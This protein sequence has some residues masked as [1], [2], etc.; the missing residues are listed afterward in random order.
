L[1][2]DD[3]DYDDDDDDDDDEEEVDDDAVMGGRHS[4]LRF[5]DS[6]VIFGSSA[7]ELIRTKLL[8]SEL[9]YASRDSK[10][11]SLQRKTIATERRDVGVNKSRNNN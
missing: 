11:P 8:T 1:D 5:R 2:D 9:L 3:Y 6:S 10:K 4:Y 7:E